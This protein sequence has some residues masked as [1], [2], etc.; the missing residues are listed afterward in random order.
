MPASKLI[1]SAQA[2]IAATPEYLP[3]RTSVWIKACLLALICA[4]AALPSSAQTFKPLFSFDGTNGAVPLGPLTQGL[5]GNFYGTTPDFGAHNAGTVFRITPNGTLATIYNFCAQTNCT[6]GSAPEA[7]LVLGR[8]GSF[9][10]TTYYGGGGNCESGCGTVFKITPQGALTSLYSFTGDADGSRPQE[11]PLIQA[12]DGNFYGSTSAGGSNRFNGGGTIFRITPSG[13]LTTAYRFPYTDGQYPNGGN[14]QG[15]LLQAAD[16]NFYGTTAGGGPYNAGTVFQLTPAGT[17]T[18]L[19]NFCSG[20]SP[21]VDGQYPSGGL[22]L[23]TDG[24]LYGTTLYGGTS[25]LCNNGPFT[26]CGTVFTISL[27]GTL[28][29]LHS[30]VNTDGNNPQPIILATD[31][32]FYGTTYI[33]GDTQLCT[34]T[35]I[36]G[37]CGVIY[38]ITSA[39]TF[40]LLHIF[41][42]TDGNSPN[43]LLQGTNGAFYGTTRYGG[44][45]GYDYGAVYGLGVGLAPFVESLPPYGKVGANVRILGNNLKGATSVTFNG[46][47]ATFAVIS[48]SYI[49]TT[50]PSGATT[51]S[52]KVTTPAGTLTSNVVFSVQP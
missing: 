19:Y 34:N 7:A 49:T 40:T 20:G 51:G 17:L 44:P 1:R 38:K 47:A 8:D 13:Q 26:D 12:T 45:S 18:T 11:T 39:G 9:Y 24:K 30:F 2:L 43:V 15:G 16:G 36:E 10:G 3:L 42:G 52:I 35:D 41:D 29:T 50:V 33:G 48:A 28:T 14:A 27:A 5:D 25:T 31:G 37:G 4:A 6:D 22:V 46:T 23:G 32:N 21:C